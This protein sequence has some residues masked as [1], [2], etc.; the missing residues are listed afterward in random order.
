MCSKYRFDSIQATSL[1]HWFCPAWSVFLCMLMDKYDGSRQLFLIFFKDSGN[2]NQCGCMTIM[3]TSM[4]NSRV[5]RF[6]RDV[7]FLLDRQRTKICPQC[8]GSTWFVACQC[9]NDTVS[10]NSGFIWNGKVII[11]LCYILRCFC[12]L[13]RQLGI[14]V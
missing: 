13:K 5:F 9:C 12:F 1:N 4:H 8:N 14:L 3:T 2:S 7:I 10:A 11:N 6:V